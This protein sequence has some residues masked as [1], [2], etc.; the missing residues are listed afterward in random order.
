[1]SA[2]FLIAYLRT[3]INE[4]L[5]NKVKGDKGGETWKGIA[6]LI[7]PN[8]EGWILIDFIK[9]GI[10]FPEKF[11]K[12]DVDKLNKLL[13]ASEKLELLVRKFY[14][15]EFWDKFRGDELMIQIVANPIYDSAVNYG[16]T[17]AISLAQKSLKIK[18][19]G[20]MD[21]LTLNTLNNKV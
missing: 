3:S 6:R 9:Q 2:D 15:T 13:N 19:S 5:W 1:M 18:E 14:K 8:W 16:P 12:K 4:G 21:Q 10:N 11:I 20:I 7:H 17:R